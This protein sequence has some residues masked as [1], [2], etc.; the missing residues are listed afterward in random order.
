MLRDLLSAAIRASVDLNVDAGDRQAWTD[1]LNRLAPIPTTTVNGQRVYALADPGTVSDGRAIRP[2]DNTVN[3]EFIHPGEVLGLGSPAGDRQTAIDTLNVMNSWGQNNSF[4]KVFTQAAR[5][6]YP[7]A[8]LIDRLRGQITANQVAN[9]RIQDGV[10]GLEK[11]GAIEAIDN[12]LL[13]SGGGVMRV[14][15]VWPGDRNASFVKLREKN[16]FLVSSARSANRVSYVDI[17]S[18]A[19]K[20]VQLQNPWPGLNISVTRV[21]GGSVAFTVPNNVITFPTQSG[22]TYT[23]TAS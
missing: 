16:A 8:N 1:I 2:G 19:G 7:A 10:H 15:P 6:G 12:L 3:L 13:Q 20:Q 23:I 17:T 9:L 21:G 14:F 18:E 11:S 22:A 4:P 5:V